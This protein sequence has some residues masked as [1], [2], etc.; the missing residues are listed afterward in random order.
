MNNYSLKDAFIH[1]PIQFT[2]NTFKKNS[3]D[4]SINSNDAT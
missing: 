3:P 4:N 1:W 2:N